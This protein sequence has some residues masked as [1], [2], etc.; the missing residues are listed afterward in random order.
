MSSP[1]WVTDATSNTA[2]FPTSLLPWS[3][4]EWPWPNGTVTNLL[5]RYDALLSLTRQDPERLQRLTAPQGRVIFALDGLQPDVGHEV[6]WVLRDCLSG[7][8]L[9]AHS[10]LSASHT[11]LAALLQRVKQARRVPIG[12]PQAS[13]SR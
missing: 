3:S 5:E 4:V 12:V 6:L 8:V 13:N 9:L 10:V 11:D 2:V 7:E 1:W